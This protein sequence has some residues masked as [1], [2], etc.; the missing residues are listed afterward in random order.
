MQ[1]FDGHVNQK[2]FFL[3]PEE[4]NKLKIKRNKYIFS[5]SLFSRNL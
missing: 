2:L 5:L 3:C 4:E 1:I